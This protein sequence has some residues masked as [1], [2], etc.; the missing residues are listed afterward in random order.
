MNWLLAVGYLV[1]LMI[2]AHEVW[3]LLLGEDDDDVWPPY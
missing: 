2:L 1:L 3:G